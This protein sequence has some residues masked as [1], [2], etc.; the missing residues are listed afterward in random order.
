MYH[1]WM[2]VLLFWKWKQRY[3]SSSIIK[4][5]GKWIFKSSGTEQN[6]E[7]ICPTVSLFQVIP[8][9]P[10]DCWVL[11]EDVSHTTDSGQLWNLWNVLTR[12]WISSL[13]SEHRKWY[14]MPVLLPA[15]P[16]LAASIIL[17][18]ILFKKN[19]HFWELKKNLH[20]RSDGCRVQVCLIPLCFLVPVMTEGALKK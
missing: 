1:P 17:L 3:A 10:E 6:W 12:S 7:N 5:E 13:K 19:Y 18:C 14:C 2:Q 4:P 15:S 11:I 20:S 16:S 8:P 9:F